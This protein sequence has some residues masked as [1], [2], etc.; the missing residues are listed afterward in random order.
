MRLIED[1]K[2]QNEEFKDYLS[3]SDNKFYSNIDKEKTEQF[4]EKHFK[5]HFIKPLTEF[6]KIPNLSPNFDPEFCTNGLIDQAI[7]LI[8]NFA[9]SLKIPN[10]EFHCHREEG[11]PPIVG[12]VYPGNSALNVVVYGHIDKQPHLE[13]WIPGTGP[14]SAKIIGDLMYGR[15]SSDDGYT[16]FATLL[17]LKN[18]ID[19]GVELPRVCIVLETEEE[20]GSEH[21]PELLE[22]CSKWI[23]VPDILF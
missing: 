11:M 5:S 21:L 7:E 9:E 19:Q 23:G 2:D 15:G 1:F 13:G 20:S 14:L 3:F 18:A 17:A 22:K 10:L 8:Q 16:S 4:I 12:I 6:V